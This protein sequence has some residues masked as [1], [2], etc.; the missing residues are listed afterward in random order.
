MFVQ[1]VSSFAKFIPER[2]GKS[3]IAQGAF[4]FAGLNSFEAGQ[5]HAPHAH[6]GQDKFYLVLEGSGL[7]QVGDQ[8]ER[9]SAGDVAF[10]PSESSIQFVI[11]GRS[12]WL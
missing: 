11:Q 2:M 9:L 6:D 1:R 8:T 5:E 10:A 3:T 12:G 7:V 4:L